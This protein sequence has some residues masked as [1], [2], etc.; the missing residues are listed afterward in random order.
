MK[1]LFVNTSKLFAFLLMGLGQFTF[2]SEVG[3][4]S[5]KI[6]NA[7]YSY[8]GKTATLNVGDHLPVGSEVF[9]EEGAQV[10]LNDYFDHKYHLSGSGHIVLHKNLIE[11]QQGYIWIQ[12]L[13]DP[14][15]GTEFNVTTANAQLNYGKGEV[16]MSF[17]THSEKT[18]VF[19]IKGRFTFQNVLQE[20]YKTEVREGDFSYIHNDYEQGHPR[21][22]THLGRGSYNK[23]VS[24]FKGVSPLGK[25]DHLKRDRPNKPSMETLKRSLASVQ[26]NM[27]TNDIFEQAL[28]AQKE[29]SAPKEMST[30]IAPSSKKMERR[31]MAIRPIG[32]KA[33]EKK[34]EIVVLRQVEPEEEK[35]KVE[36]LLKMYQS[37]VHMLANK[38]RIKKKA[39]K[40]NRSK[41]SN[42]SIHIF[43]KKTYPWRQKKTK[44]KSYPIKAKSQMRTKK[45]YRS[46]SSV[47]SLSLHT[48]TSHS[49]ASVGGMVPKV[50]KRNSFDGGLVEQYKRQMRHEQEVNSLIDELK[51]V[52]MDYKKDY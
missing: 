13:I 38:P 42:V 39:W 6:G 9:T 52:D 23:I 25:E 32:P 43:G 14:E 51:S 4:V 19:A 10:S 33:D 41:K 28:K 2:A 7:F 1:T 3:I 21:R 27:K 50:K 18:Q 26:K 48:E 36:E 12:S 11:L 35:M 46:P 16:V 8:A 5:S 47:P 22:A 34:K 40:P 24:L 45:S 44:Q 37:K 20:H 29:K 17:D 49:P 15:A 31:K 30:G